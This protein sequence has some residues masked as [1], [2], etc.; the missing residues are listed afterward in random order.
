MSW[1]K[2]RRLWMACFL[3]VTVS[4]TFGNL[5]LTGSSIVVHCT[6]MPPS[7]VQSMEGTLPQ[8][9]KKGESDHKKR[10]IL[11]TRHRI[12]DSLSDVDSESQKQ[13]TEQH[14]RTQFIAECRMPSTFGPFR[15]RSYL[16]TSP[17]QKL[18]PI[19]MISGDIS[20]SENILVRVHD[21]CFTSEVLGSLRCDC[22]EQ[23]HESLK[24]INRESG[25]LIY[26]QQEGRGIGLPNKIA[27]YSLQ[28]LG[29]DT[30]DANLHLGFQEEQREYNVIPDILADLGIK[31]IR[32]LTNNPYKISELRCLGVNIVSRVPILIQPNE[33]N[34][35]YLLSKRDRMN[36]LMDSVDDVPL[37]PSDTMNMNINI[38]PS[39]ISNIIP[40]ILPQE[41]SRTFST[42]IDKKRASS[43][44]VSYDEDHDRQDAVT[45]TAKTTLPSHLPATF[46]MNKDI[47]SRYVFGRESV[48]AAIQSIRGGG[49]VVVVDD[50]NRENEGDLIMAAEKATEQSIGFFVRYTSGVICV[51]MEGER[52]DALDLPPMVQNNEDPKKT[53]YSIT[54]DCKHNTT[55]GISAADRAITFRALANPLSKPNDFQRPGHV[56]PLR[57]R[58]GGVLA[59][60]GHTEA[61]LD[62]ARLAGLSAAGVLAEIVDDQG[63][64]VRLNGLKEF[65]QIHGLVLTSVQDL[66]A[67]RI[68]ISDFQ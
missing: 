5:F 20:S 44:K 42:T 39:E 51:S 53:A 15:M 56:F 38:L 67:Y 65:A 48:E 13:K 50:E 52:L 18:E 68:E 43:S 7:Y 63:A 24:R 26:L 47:S 21:Q 11:F 17:T 23:L 29:Y 58:P 4:K 31:S 10:R 40:E 64:M 46:V 12:E 2:G 59:R 14:R 33:F 30:V 16:Y 37:L 45:M 19:V 57:Y 3:L 28:D 34:N 41:S 60:P 27:A 9:S 1:K 66:I 54:V 6:E 25:V 35:K 8:D 55:T 62:L 61:S 36:H 32:L 22:R 49:I